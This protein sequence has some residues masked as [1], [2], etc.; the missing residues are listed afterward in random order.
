MSEPVRMGAFVVTMNLDLVCAGGRAVPIV[1]EREIESSVLAPLFGGDVHFAGEVGVLC[2][3]ALGLDG[4]DGFQVDHGKEG[5]PEAERS[6]IELEEPEQPGLSAG[7][8]EP[9][10]AASTYP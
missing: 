2:A 1:R 7:R 3:D 10:E 8:G 6:A 4:G 5:R 9:R